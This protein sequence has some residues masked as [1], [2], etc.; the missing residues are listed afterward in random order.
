MTRGQEMTMTKIRRITLLA[1]LACT[2][3]AAQPLL[4]Q[5]PAP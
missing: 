2:A 4:A 1:V 5:T 3:A